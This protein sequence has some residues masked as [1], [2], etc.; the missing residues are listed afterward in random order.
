[1]HIWGNSHNKATIMQIKAVSLSYILFT[2]LLISN[3]D[4]ATILRVNC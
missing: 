3:D 4:I 1:M 2:F